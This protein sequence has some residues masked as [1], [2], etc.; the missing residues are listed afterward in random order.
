MYNWQN[1]VISQFSSA[2]TLTQLIENFNEYLDPTANIDAF[3]QYIWNVDTAEGFGLQV[4]GK[5][6]GV[7]NVIEIPAGT[8]WFGFLE[9][10]DYGTVGFGQGPF[11]DGVTPLLVNFNLSDDDYRTLILAK[12]LAN[13]SN[14]SIPAINQILL[15]L[16]PGRGNCYVTDGED[17]TMTYTFEFALTAVELAIMT[18]SG[19]LPKPVGVFA[20][21]VTV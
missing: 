16:F 3:Y 2:A 18:Q 19:V 17:M 4:W 8:P 21:V 7:S 15:N 12:A 1:T 11:W 6:V 14:G 5:I 13:I 9:T 20:S 10:I